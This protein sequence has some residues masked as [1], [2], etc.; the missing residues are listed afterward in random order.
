MKKSLSEESR[1]IFS[2]KENAIQHCRD[3][4]KRLEQNLFVK[5]V[6]Y[7]NNNEEEYQICMVDS[8]IIFC[9][10]NNS[11]YIAEVFNSNGQKYFN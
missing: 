8:F 7:G 2:D 9:I 5:I 11:K 1:I 6:P 4:A 3:L 10:C